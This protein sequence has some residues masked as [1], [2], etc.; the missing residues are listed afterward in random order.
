[1]IRNSFIFLPRIGLKKEQSIW[2]QGIKDWNDF[3]NNEVKGISKKTKAFYNRKIK[4]ARNALYN[5]NSSWF[6]NTLPSTEAWRL[7]AFFKDQSVFLDIETSGTS[8][9]SYLTIMCIYNGYETK[10]M[11]F[12]NF[13]YKI[14]KQYLARYKLLVTFNG[15]SFDIPFLNK[16]YPGL[17]PNIPHFDLRHTCKKIGLKG[18]L[19][20]IEKQLGIKRENEIVQRFY[21]GDPFKLWRMY[22]GS[23][24]DYYL[25]LLVKYNEEDTIN[26]EKIADYTYTKLKETYLKP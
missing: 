3:L 18:G 4:E 6:N 8:I 20:K 25:N 14:L 13:N 19:K 10:T 11:T 5:G 2:R 26:L 22:K 9:K 7:Y 24:N 17:L 15:L 21:G 12:F 1:M 23:G 16:K